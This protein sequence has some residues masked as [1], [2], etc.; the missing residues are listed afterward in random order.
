MFTVQHQYRFRLAHN[1]PETCVGVP[2]AGCEPARQHHHGGR[3]PGAH[4]SY[5]PAPG[6]ALRLTHRPQEG[7]G[8]LAACPSLKPSR[9]PLIASDLDNSVEIKLLASSER[10][11]SLASPWMSPINAQCSSAELAMHFEAS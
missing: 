4:P 9:T 5:R 10:L 2:R 11:G 8:E 3:Q 6:Q 1:P 7:Q